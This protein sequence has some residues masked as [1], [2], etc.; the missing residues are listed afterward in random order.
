MTAAEKYERLL[1]DLRSRGGAAVAFSAGVDSTL[2]LY[3]AKVALGEKAI[4][5]NAVSPLIPQSERREAGEKQ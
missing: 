4:A 5:V 2:L 3:A 1:C